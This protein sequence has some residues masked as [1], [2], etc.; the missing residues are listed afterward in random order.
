MGSDYIN[1]AVICVVPLVL[2]VVPSPSLVAG[3][4]QGNP[5]PWSKFLYAKSDYQ[6]DAPLESTKGTSSQRMKRT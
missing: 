2:A 3:Y 6:H 4:S 1:E 5:I